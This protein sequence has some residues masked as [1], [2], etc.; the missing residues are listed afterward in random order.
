VV[1]GSSIFRLRRKSLPRGIILSVGSF[2][3]ALHLAGFPHIDN[4]HGSP[5]EF[6]ALVLAAW[7]MGE[8]ARCLQRRWNL[9]HAGIILLLYSD[10]MILTGIVALLAIS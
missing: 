5:W 9:Y 7:G 10:L 6:L 2:L 3:L 4:L 8:T 1:P